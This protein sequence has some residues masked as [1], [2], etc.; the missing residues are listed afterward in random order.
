[1]SAVKAPAPRA[2]VATDLPD[3]DFQRIDDDRYRLVIPSCK[4]TLEVD[5]LRRERHQLIGELYVACDIAGA[6]QIDG[7]LHL[8]DFN[9]SSALA[10]TQRAKILADRSQAED[11]DWGSFVE[12]LCQ[13]VIL[14]ERDGSPARLL[15]SFEPSGADGEY[16]VDGWRLLR[17]HPTIL[18]GDGGSL[19]SYLALY[20]A[21]RLAGRGVQVLYV[22]WELVGSDHRTRLERLFGTDMP[23][24]HY[25]RCDRPLIIEVDRLR[26]EIHRLSIDYAIF[27]SVAFATG[28]PP[29]NADQATAY[30]RATRQLGIGTLH[31][32][33]VNRAENG[34]Q[35]PFGS[36]FWHNSARSTWFVKQAS[37]GLDGRLTVGLYNRKS[38][39]TRLYPALGFRF[40]FN[41]ASG[42][43]PASTVVSPTAVTENEEL[44]PK[45][46]LWQ[47]VHHALKSGPLSLDEIAAAV[48]TETHKIKK[49]IERSS[50]KTFM[51]VPSA[52]GPR[53]S[54]VS[55]VEEDGSVGGHR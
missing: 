23:A 31:L 46:P 55:R 27:D 14:R 45:A 3:H 30:F 38:N 28:G 26:R 50:K 29:E 6:K 10:R 18:F 40:E 4:T 47:R 5:R 49:L 36:A 1:M 15:T 42:M 16:N 12:E 20:A 48:G 11:L 8:A 51:T 53:I 35:K 13:R 7:C 19:K 32:A 33:H 24:L 43:H 34:D 41:D 21:G 39:L 52:N 37:P 54:L 44:A 25:V 17:D 2:V 9:L 22:D